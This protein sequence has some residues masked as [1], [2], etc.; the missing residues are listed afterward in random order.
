MMGSRNPVTAFELCYS[1]DQQ[2]TQW[3]PVGRMGVSAGNPSC[4]GFV[5]AFGSHETG[6]ERRPHYQEPFK[7]DLMIY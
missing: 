4:L 2:C 5:I 1:R 3:L 7:V 6:T